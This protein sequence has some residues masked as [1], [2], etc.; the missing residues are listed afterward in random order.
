MSWTQL[1]SATTLMN[2]ASLMSQGLLKKKAKFFRRRH[3]EE[4]W[5]HRTPEPEPSLT[6]LVRT[7]MY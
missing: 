2:A 3:G 5:R 6:K 1:A 7:P 4:P